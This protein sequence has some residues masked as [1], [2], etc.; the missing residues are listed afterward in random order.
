MIPLCL[1]SAFPFEGIFAQLRRFIAE[2]TPNIPKQVLENLMLNK[3]AAAHNGAHTCALELIF[4]PKDKSTISAFLS[5]L[6]FLFYFLPIPSLTL[7]TFHFFPD[8]DSIFYLYDSQNGYSFWRVTKIKKDSK[9]L[10]AE[11]MNHIYIEPGH[12]VDW[13]R[14]GVF[15]FSG[16]GT[17][18][19]TINKDHING[20]AMLCRNFIISIPFDVMNEV[21]F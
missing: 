17:E 20:K 2:G 8:D 1:R 13:S 19:C 9:I 6:Q 14:V 12:K 11:K 10:Q 15:K 18:T 16:Q 5:F 4:K 7:P 21:L 3:L